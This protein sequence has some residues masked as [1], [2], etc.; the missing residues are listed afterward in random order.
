MRRGR[1]GSSGG[2]ASRPGR[3]TIAGAMLAVALAGVAT[4]AWRSG[5]EDWARSM[6]LATSATMTLAAVGAACRTGTDRAWWLGAALFGWGYLALACLGFPMPTGP[7][8][9]RLSGLSV[10]TG[11]RP[12][13]AGGFGCV[14]GIGSPSV[15]YLIHSRH[16]I[17][18]CLASLGVALLGGQLA[19]VLF[20]G[21][22]VD[23]EPVPIGPEPGAIRWAWRRPV[24]VG[25]ATI[26]A[27]GCAAPIGLRWAPG[28]SAAA[29][30][31]AT[32]S[33]ISLG[34][35]GAVAGRGPRRAAC[36]GAALF[37]A[38]YMTTV[39]GPA[40]LPTN[41]PRVASNGLLDALR[42]QLP[43]SVFESNADVAD[44]LARAN[45]R[46]LGWLDRPITLRFPD[47]TPLEVFL[48]AIEVETRGPDGHG[49]AFYLDPPGFQEA[50]K[51]A[52][53]PVTLNL[54][55]VR[56]R[57]ALRFALNQLSLT[58]LVIDGVLVITSREIDPSLA[59]TADLGSTVALTPFHVVGQCLLASMATLLGGTLS[60]LVLGR[61]PTTPAP[62]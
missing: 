32:W 39:F 38:G 37:G 58:Y 33:V 16:P 31:L 2:S 47:E 14:Y 12:N 21:R 49:V 45:A 23:R 1:N 44:P 48:K 7:L 40:T 5:S 18:H 35:V 51:T 27:A 3:S 57:T 17:G 41:W 36:L 20:G 46:V 54:E 53:S 59:Q 52:T 29:A 6:I 62:A 9:D 25:A 50:E 8:L 34:A 55:G 13:P 10:A 15:H 4:A 56:L 30:L 60:P 11:G 22:V 42:A 24:L 26:L 43:D 19:R 28:P 61:K